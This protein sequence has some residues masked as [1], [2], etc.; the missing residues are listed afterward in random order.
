MGGPSTAQ[1]L[2]DF[3]LPNTKRVYPSSDIKALEEE[4]KGSNDPDNYSKDLLS[5]DI[6]DESIIQ[7][8]SEKNLRSLT[9]DNLQEKVYNAISEPIFHQPL[10]R[11]PL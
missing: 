2:Y 7:I 3:P 10:P 11:A 4:V 1:S 8:L 5:H 6:F 9:E